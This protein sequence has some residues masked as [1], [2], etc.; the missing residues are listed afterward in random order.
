M[1]LNGHASDVSDTEPVSKAGLDGII[2]PRPWDNLPVCFP[3]SSNIQPYEESALVKKLQT[4]YWWVGYPKVTTGPDPNSNFK[5]RWLPFASQ[6][7]Q[8]ESRIELT[9]YQVVRECLW[10][11][12][13]AGKSFLF[14]S[15][16]NNEFLTKNLCLY[17]RKPASLTHLTYGA[18]DAFCTEI[19]DCATC[20]LQI[21]A[22][23]NFVLLSGCPTL[24]PF[25]RLA[26]ICER[27]R[28]DAFCTISDLEQEAKSPSSSRLTLISLSTKWRIWSRRLSFMSALILQVC[29]PQLNTIFSGKTSIL[30]LNR[31]EEL[32]RTISSSFPDPYLVNLIGEVFVTATEAYL[33]NIM[34][35]SNFGNTPFLLYNDEIPPTHPQ[36]WQFGITLI[37]SS[38]PNVLS[39]VIYEIF[40]GAKSLH[41]LKAISSAFRNQQLLS[42]IGSS[43]TPLSHLRKDDYSKDDGVR[44]LEAYD[45][46]DIRDMV[47]FMESAILNKPG[48]VLLESPSRKK[49][50]P[51]PEKAVKC[52]REETK[53]RASRISLHLVSYLLR[54]PLAP[55]GTWLSA[56]SSFADFL[57]LIHAFDSLAA[58]AF[59][60][61]GEW[62]Y[63]FC[64]EVFS[65]QL[66]NRTESALNKALRDQV[67]AICGEKSWLC[68]RLHLTLGEDSG[69]QSTFH[70]LILKINIPWPLNIIISESNLAI[71]QNVFKFL[72]VLKHA[73]WT[74]DKAKW[75]L[76]TGNHK[77]AVLR[78]R[79]LYVI[80]GLHAFIVDHIE[81][82]H[83]EFTSSLAKPHVCTCLDNLLTCLGAYLIRVNE[84]CLLSENV[85]QK[86]INQT[87]RELFDL[88]AKFQFP[89]DINVQYLSSEF[90]TRV[91]F[92][93]TVLSE[94]L[95]GSGN[96]RMEATSLLKMLENSC[97]F[98]LGVE[99]RLHF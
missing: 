98:N 3:P 35:G 93:R 53:Q 61:S 67:T 54:G 13:G 16:T 51:F 7:R 5:I 15:Y 89:S 59:F 55:P 76:E 4:E 25:S 44:E 80:N 85:S 46:P 36:F 14:V 90:S 52:L 69:S 37:N 39:S 72:F 45:D 60:R 84:I 49:Q 6:S 28:R 8:C 40:I 50:T 71:Y 95:Q 65:L 73:K 27:L 24:S 94:A 79:C 70:D 87:L 30:L 63:A 22:F 18:L 23:E 43:S 96:V 41:L 32:S 81:T 82:A 99:T 78:S 74:L 21:K 10:T 92:L 88:C 12:L 91:G 56:V 68:E 66:C 64:E 33:S 97:Q 20:I 11:L 31:L 75:T 2:F 62:M 1:S 47:E 57:N 17:T 77:L 26:Q 42:I 48:H 9:E 19:A 29:S 34:C 58:V 38:V 86:M 83:L